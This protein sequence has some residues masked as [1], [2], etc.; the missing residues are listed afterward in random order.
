[1][2]NSSIYHEKVDPLRPNSAHA[3][4]LDMVGYGKRVLE[5]GCG[6]GHITRILR[7]RGCRVTGL[8]HDTAAEE[9]AGQFADR[10][11]VVDLATEDFVQ[12]LEGEEFDVAL[13]GDVL[14]H[15]PDP[16]TVLRSAMTLLRRGG[17]TVVS[18]P[19]IAHA[20]VR[21]SLVRGQFDYQPIGLLDDTHLRFFTLNSIRQLLREAGLVATETRRVICPPF[22]YAHDFL[23]DLVF[24]MSDCDEDVKQEALN[25]PS[26][27]LSHLNL[28]RSQNNNH[29]D[30][31]VAPPGDHL[32]MTVFFVDPLTGAEIVS[33]DQLPELENATVASPGE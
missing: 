23:M 11:L 21:L 25:I 14:E 7:E 5:F 15:L 8:D 18:I 3:F 33:V 1:M 24:V 32:P 29:H 9:E 6:P 30:V 10:V 27:D 28:L 13:F 19:N 16:L 12:K 22:S 2:K 17:Y 26:S 4:A 20:D 31:H